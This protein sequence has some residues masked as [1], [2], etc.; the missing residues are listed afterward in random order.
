LEIFE[1][2]IS[3]WDLKLRFSSSSIPRSLK[4]FSLLYIPAWTGR[5]L[6]IFI[7]LHFPNLSYPFHP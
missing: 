3:M 4:L 5:F 1:H 2:S 7:F 6:A